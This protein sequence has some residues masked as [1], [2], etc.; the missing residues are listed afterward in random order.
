[1]APLTSQPGG[2]TARPDPILGIQPRAPRMGDGGDVVGPVR[3]NPKGAARWARSHR[4][5]CALGQ[6]QGPAPNPLNQAHPSREPRQHQCRATKGTTEAKSCPFWG[7][8]QQ[9]WDQGTTQEGPTSTPYIP[10]GAQPRCSRHPLSPRLP[11]ALAG[12]HGDS[13]AS[14][15]DVPAR[16]DWICATEGSK[17]RAPATPGYLGRGCR[18]QSCCR[19][20]DAQLASVGCRRGRRGG[21]VPELSRGRAL[22]ISVTWRQVWT[23]TL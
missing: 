3:A 7:C 13:P 5:C 9:G 11:P 8:H 17:G 2:D 22:G 1:M 6:P 21:A 14:V 10:L 4:T 19:C 20:L 15:R 23:T 16:S 18:E 12:K